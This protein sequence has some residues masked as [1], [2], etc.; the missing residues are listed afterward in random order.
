MNYP[1]DLNAHYVQYNTI[2][3]VMSQKRKWPNTTGAAI[4][5]LGP[6]D[7]MLKC[8][9]ETK[10]PY[11]TDTER[12]SS[13]DVIDIINEELRKEWTIFPRG[14]TEIYASVR[15]EERSNLRAVWDAL[16]P[17]IR[18]PYRHKFEDANMLL[19][20]GDDE[21][22][23]ELIDALEPTAKIAADISEGGMMETFTA[24]KAGF[25]AGI[26]NLTPA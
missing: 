18:G 15:V 20:E 6:S 25:A 17:Y 22:A 21:T 5:G 9:E 4:D 8:V 26:S 1:V 14:D 11:N 10:P 23:A 12:L 2:T 19:N 3:G 7:I 16:P 13:G 24:V